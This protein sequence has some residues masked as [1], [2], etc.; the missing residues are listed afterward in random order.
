MVRTRRQVLRFIAAAGAA[1][2][3]TL[4]RR[5]RARAASC[6][7]TPQATAGPY[8]VDELLERSDITVDPS[9]GS[10]RPGVPLHLDLTV[11]RA[12]RNCAPAAGVQ[13]D[14]WH[15]DAGGF[16]SDEAANNTVGR[17]FLRGYQI[18]D[19]NGAVRF[20]TIST[21]AGTRAGRSTS[22]SGSAPS[23]QR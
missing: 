6:T 5:G 13:V 19:A 21:P 17:K 18:A 14:V 9:N 22:T 16:Y 3:V 4:A 10:V 12:D 1:L 7:V 15:C 20:T 2:L 8:W 23:T 11:F